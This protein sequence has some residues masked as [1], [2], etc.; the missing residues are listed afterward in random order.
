MNSSE[1]IEYIKQ[2]DAVDYIQRNYPECGNFT[3]GEP[4]MCNCFLP[5]HLHTGKNTPSLAVYN[6]N[7][8]TC[9]SC[10]STK[11]SDIIN[12]EAI[13]NG[14]GTTG[15]D[16]LDVLDII[17]HKEG[18]DFDRDKNE[19][20][21]ATSILKDKK[22]SLVKIYEDYLW[23]NKNSLCFK[24]LKDQ[25]QLTEQTIADF[26]LGLTPKDEYKRR[27]DMSNISDK[28]V[29]P[30]ISDNG[31][32]ISALSYRT[33]NNDTP[34]YKNEKNDLIFSKRSTL[35]GLAHAR[36]SIRK[37]NHMFIVEGYFDT[38]SL[39][40][41]GIKNV[42]AV[43]SNTITEE[44]ADKISKICKNVTIIMDQDV[45]GLKQ[46]IANINLLLSRDINVRIISNLDFI[47]KDIAD[48]CIALKWDKRNIEI[49][50]SKHSKDAYSELLNP[51]L[52]S[53][54]ESVL[55]L[56]EKSLRFA[57]SV[58]NNIKDE[59]KKTVLLNKIYKRLNIKE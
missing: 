10:G 16:F 46:K 56:Q 27:N 59:T 28:L 57:M 42:I 45:A 29:I 58:I 2:I 5:G 31:K 24:Y 22:K 48:L 30:I 40:Q 26:H 3:T 55:L 15:D 35:Y 8:I 39:Y 41:A 51:V 37:S 32:Y 1:M 21:K 7:T 9:F 36:D 11:R 47:G 25:R 12:L 6:D 13:M 43:M 4:R 53:F 54:D 52:D 14:L 44:Q 20:S 34:K 38:I 19:D 49:F 23:N 17:A 18:I 50:L 33:L